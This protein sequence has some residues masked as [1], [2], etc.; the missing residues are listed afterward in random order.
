MSTAQQRE[1]YA[2][3]SAMSRRARAPLVWDRFQLAWGAQTWVMGII[4]VTPD[5]FSGDGLATDADATAWAALA[6][7]QGTQQAQ[8]G[9]RI[10]DVGGASS[11]P[12]APTIAPAVEISRVVP[13]V[14]ALAATL[15]R[16]IPI[17][18]DTTSAAV[19][20]AALA[21]GANLI[22]DI[23]GL[24][25]DPGMAP[26][27]AATGVPV[28]VM[29]NRRLIPQHEVVSDVTRYLADSIER[30]LAAGVPWEHIIIDPG[31]GFGNTPTENVTLLRHLDALLALN[32]PILLGVSRKSTLGTI[33]G[34]VPVTERREASLA[35]AVVGV[36]H[37][38]DIVRVHDV[39]ATV[40]ALRVAD[41]IVR[42][43]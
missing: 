41:A 28:I 35:A 18:I 7:A 43:A 30:A 36:L 15:P 27:V 1:L 9:A 8:E 4:N 5:S 38:A 22:N 39:Q 33:L 37:G 26:L 12:G 10:V 20:R 34:D 6:V 2:I 40:R 16:D 29:A 17:S 21:A 31:F 23:S 3:L 25:A 13:T 14:R 32:C 11:R 42:E 24:R 19:A